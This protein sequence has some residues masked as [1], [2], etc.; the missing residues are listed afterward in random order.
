MPCGGRPPTYKKWSK[1]ISLLKIPICIHSIL[2][3]NKEASD[4][5]ESPRKRPRKGQEKGKIVQRQ[6]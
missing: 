6:K 4:Q 3:E 5:S 1:T 2:P